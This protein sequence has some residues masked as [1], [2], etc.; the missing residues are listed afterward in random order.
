MESAVVALIWVVASVIVLGVLVWATIAFIAI[1]SGKR[2]SDK[3]L[4]SFD[5]S[6]QDK[7]NRPPYP[8][9]GGHNY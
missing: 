3:V 9:K 6:G 5:E 2:I 7:M 4:S 8:H 1:R